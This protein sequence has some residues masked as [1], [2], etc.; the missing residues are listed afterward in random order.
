MQDSLEVPNLKIFPE[1]SAHLANM[2][3]TWSQT[4]GDA[5]GM[6]T[7]QLSLKW[8]LTDRILS[9]S[10]WSWNRKIAGTYRSLSSL[11]SRESLLIAAL[12]GMEG[13]LSGMEGAL[14]V[15]EGLGHRVGKDE[16]V[17]C[18]LFQVSSCPLEVGTVL[19]SLVPCAAFGAVNARE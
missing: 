18:N 2:A 5:H 3:A 1:L 15:S 9:R 8:M 19:P 4:F 17:C 6:L 10:S 7:E 13:A 16:G 12:S 14:S 11:L